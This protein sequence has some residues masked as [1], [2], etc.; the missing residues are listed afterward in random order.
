[1]Y[2]L[3]S[4]IKIFSFVLMAVGLLGLAYGFIAAPS[5]IEDAAEYI[6]GH[7]GHGEEEIEE[8]PLQITEDDGIRADHGVPNLPIDEEEVDPEPTEIEPMGLDTASEKDRRVREAIRPEAVPQERVDDQE[9]NLNE[10]DSA[11]NAIEEVEGEETHLEGEK[12]DET[13]HELEDPHQE[14]LLHVLHQLKNRPWSALFVAGF[15]FFMLALGTLVFYA[16]QYAAKAGWSPVL[17]RVMEGITGYLL[18]GS[19]I[20]FLI[21]IFGGSH[22]YTWQ[23]E[24]IVA[25]DEIL[26]G[27]AGYLNLPFFII[28]LVIYLVGWNVY[29]YFSR[30]NSIRLAEA[31]NIDPH[32]RNYRIS[33]YFLIFFIITEAFFAIDLFMSLTPHWYSSLFPWYVFA[34]MFVS[35]ITTIALIVIFLKRMGHLSFVNDS[36]LHD[37]SKYIFAFSIFWTYLW[38]G[39][40]MLIWY[41]NIPEE[42]TYFT[43]I[44]EEYNMLFFGMLVLNFVFPILLLM[45]SDFK[46]VPWFV[47]LTGIVV[48]IGH[49]IDIFILIMPPTVGAH[50]FFGIPEIAAVCFFLGLFIFVVGTELG[51]VS[52]YPKGDP[53]LKE[54]ENYHY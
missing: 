52:L 14:H 46:R 24:S 15:F 37:L 36:H 10:S 12:I 41:A 51:K 33:I 1:M 45:N 29:R 2:K 4:K 42:A 20:V 39:Q 27:K 43:I 32:T 8:S 6:A 25:H 21:V 35:A 53:Y 54:S 40:F 30:K 11:A 7:G 18:P 13:A 50:W 28:R 5:T 31:T 38:F 22:F 16:I 3:S 44:I 9:S 49:Y 26:Q 19:I 34:S 48:L 47:V 17:Y 23:D